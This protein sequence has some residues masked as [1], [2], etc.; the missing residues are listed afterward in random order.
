MGRFFTAEK[1]VSHLEKTKKSWFFVT[2]AFL[3]F[4]FIISIKK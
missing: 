3:F 1:K 4:V 2:M